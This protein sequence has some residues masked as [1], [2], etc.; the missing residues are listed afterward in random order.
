MAVVT[1][2]ALVAIPLQA[3]N[4]HPDKGKAVSKATDA[5]ST[6]GG[7]AARKEC[8][9]RLE[10]IEKLIDEATGAIGKGHKDHALGKLKAAKALVAEC[11]KVMAAGAKKI[12][13][14]VCP[15]MN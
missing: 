12:A 8:S 10:K 4:C 14:T 2:V 1:V 9:A 13:N 3:K 5:K 6:C 11:R 15:I 7:G